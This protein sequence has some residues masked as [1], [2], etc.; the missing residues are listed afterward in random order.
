MTKEIIN[1]HPLLNK[2]VIF[3]TA[4]STAD[5]LAATLE[6]DVE[7]DSANAALQS[8]LATAARV[9]VYFL[10]SKGGI[11]FLIELRSQRVFFCLK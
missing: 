7:E 2:S 8:L 3:F 1:L 4:Q 6:Q 5:L 10:E 11:Q 9:S